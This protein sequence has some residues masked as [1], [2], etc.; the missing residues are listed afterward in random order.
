MME[1]ERWFNTAMV[2]KVEITPFDIEAE[3][4][5]KRANMLTAVSG[6]LSAIGSLAEGVSSYKTAQARAA[7]Y[8]SNAVALASTIPFIREQGA[9]RATI[10]QQ[11]TA[12]FVGRQRAAMAANGIVV[13][14]D[15]ALEAVVQSGGLGARQVVE[16]LEAT[17]NEIEQTR[18]KIRQQE[19]EAANAKREGKAGLVSGLFKTANTILGAA[20]TIDQTNQRY[21]PVTGG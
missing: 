9:Q 21:R 10:I 13:G 6:G 17:R 1:A 7:V 12:D 19:A 16:S 14:Q 4:Q 11:E 3:R 15:T 20:S 18:S 8:A 2:A 5:R